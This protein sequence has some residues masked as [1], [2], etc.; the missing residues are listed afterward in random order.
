MGKRSSPLVKLLVMW[1]HHCRF[2]A[3]TGGVEL[4]M[5]PW[6]MDPDKN[7]RWWVLITNGWRTHHQRFMNRRW[8]TSPSLPVVKPAV[9]D[10]L[11]LAV[12][13]SYPPPRPISIDLNPTP[14]NWLWCTFQTGSDRRRWSSEDPLVQVDSTNWGPLL[15]VGVTNRDRKS[16][17]SYQ[18]RLKKDF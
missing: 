3:L 11:V 14:P 4:L 18:P 12:M 6:P 10:P 9:M 7:R 17:F 8:W 15:P 16:P 1:A 13:P 5:Y 2:V